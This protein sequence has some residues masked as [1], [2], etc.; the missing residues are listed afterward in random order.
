VS[1]QIKQYRLLREIGGEG[2]AK[3]YLAQAMTLKR[4]VAIKR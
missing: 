3:V 1:A 4:E 2:F